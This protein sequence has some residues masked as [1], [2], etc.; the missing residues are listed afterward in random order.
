M[1]DACPVE[2]PHSLAVFQG[3]ATFQP[4]EIPEAMKVLALST[5]NQS[6][7]SDQKPKKT[8]AVIMPTNRPPPQAPATP[9]IPRIRT[10]QRKS[11]SSSLQPNPPRLTPSPKTPVRKT[12]ADSLAAS[13]TLNPPS[14]PF[15]ARPLSAAGT[16]TFAR[17]DLNN[18]G[19]TPSRLSYQASNGSQALFHASQSNGALPTPS[20]HTPSLGPKFFHADGAELN[21]NYEDPSEQLRFG[22]PLRVSTGLQLNGGSQMLSPANTAGRNGNPSPPSSRPASMVGLGS[23]STPSV[24]ATPRPTSLAPSLVQ[25]QSSE[26]RNP[27]RFVYANGTE[28]LLAPRPPPEIVTATTPVPISSTF[29]LSAAS[30]GV[31]PTKNS[32]PLSPLASPSS[33]PQYFRG[34]AGSTSSRGSSA[35]VKPKHSRS[36]SIGSV[37]EIQNSV[38][39]LENDHADDEDC[40]ERDNSGASEGEG[41][42]SGNDAAPPSIPLTAAER[43]KEMEERSA[44]ARRERKV[45]DLEISNASLLAINK[46]LERQLRKQGAELRRYKRLSRSGRFT[47]T[48]S[49]SNLRSPDSVSAI[50]ESDVASI[51]DGDSEFKID[52][53]EDDEDTETEKLSEEEDEDDHDD[54][55]SVNDEKHRD[56]DEKRLTF[57][58]SKHQTLLDAN[59]K[60]N[61]SL[62]R[63]HLVT[64]VLIKEGQKAL[65]YK[66][67]PS[68]VRLGGR[69]LRAE[70]DYYESMGTNEDESKSEY[71]AADETDLETDLETEMDT[72]DEG[73]A[74]LNIDLP[75]EPFN[76]TITRHSLV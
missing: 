48:P 30:S 7:V 59:I 11:V 71:S 24:P 27:V 57:D 50:S 52:D 62:K 23:R 1:L 38:L 67:R 75:S 13:D 26:A 39:K 46:T 72:E 64:D 73:G 49:S 44:N 68:D 45:M 28:E 4:F 15:I 2:L 42:F 58:L 37:I 41:S 36:V 63:C 14:R 40:G 5:T 34:H 20:A 56:A 43:I 16:K 61:S 22:R 33:S 65:E 76:P 35:D 12:R 17:S 9:V 55:Q 66:V 18:A 74:F 53:Q 25:L 60:M 10:T 32:Y 19:T 54:S 6:P 70:D 51:A 3:Q 21:N 29:M 31:S 47:K 8:G 69:I